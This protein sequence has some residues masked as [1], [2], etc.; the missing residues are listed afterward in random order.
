MTEYDFSPDGVRCW[1]ERTG[2]FHPANPF[3]PTTPAVH[4][5]AL[6][7]SGRRSDRGHRDRERGSSGHKI[8][9]Y[10]WII[11]TAQTFAVQLLRIHSRFESFSC[12]PNLALPSTPTA[13]HNHAHPSTSSPTP[14]PLKHIPNHPPSLLP[15]RRFHHYHPSPTFLL[16][17]TTAAPRKSF[18]SKIG[19][20]FSSSS[21]L[22]S[23]AQTPNPSGVVY[24][25]RERSKS[26]KK[27]HLSRHGHRGERRNSY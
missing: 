5:M 6:K 2:Q 24:V 9:E 13:F 14:S 25:Q 10:R 15:T 17:T 26:S 12:I 19:S 23:R 8:E 16:P 1:A 7:D 18:L 3:T 27:S 20:F 4:A 21:S 22:S 11:D